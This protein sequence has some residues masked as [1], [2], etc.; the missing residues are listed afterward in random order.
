MCTGSL[1]RPEAN[2]AGYSLPLSGGHVRD[3]FGLSLI[4]RF[5]FGYKFERR[6]ASSPEHVFKSLFRFEIT[7]RLPSEIGT[8]KSERA[9]LKALPGFG[10]RER[11]EK[12][13]R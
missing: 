11:M 1:E 4:T 3:S 7:V 5:D 9:K 12:A 13:V 6:T 10:R 2:P 8:L